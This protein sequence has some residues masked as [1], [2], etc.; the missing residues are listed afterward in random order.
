MNSFSGLKKMIDNSFKK[1]CWL[2]N[3]ILAD[4]MRLN[5]CPGDIQN[6]CN[7]CGFCMAGEIASMFQL[8]PDTILAAGKL[9]IKAN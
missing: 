6:V 2:T 5:A 1:Y 8:K 3:F 9:R 7:Q 4:G